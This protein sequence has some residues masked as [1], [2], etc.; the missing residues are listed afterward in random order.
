MTRRL[1]R[2]TLVVTALVLSCAGCGEDTPGPDTAPGDTDGSDTATGDTAGDTSAPRLALG[3]SAGRLAVADGEVSRISLGAFALASFDGDLSAYNWDPWWLPGDSPLLEVFQ[4]P[5]ITWREA[6]LGETDGAFTLD[7]GTSR[8]M[9][10]RRDTP[11]GVTL[12]LDVGEVPYLRFEVRHDP[13]ELLY[14]GGNLHDGPLLNGRRVPMQLEAEPA[15]EPFYNERHVVVPLVVSSAGW[16]LWVETKRA[17]AWDVGRT[18]PGVL[19]VTVGGPVGAVRLHVF[20]VTHPLDVYRAYY[21]ESG[22]PRVPPAW[23]F[24]PWFWRDETP[25]QG[26]ATPDPR[27]NPG[28]MH[29]LATIRDLALP[30]SAYWIDRPYASA[31]NTFDFDPARYH[32]APAML[33]YARS[34]GFAMALWHTPY[35]IEEAATEHADISKIE[36]F[37]DPAGAA[38]NTFGATPVDLTNPA[39]VDYWVDRLDDYISIGIEGFKLDFAEDVVH[40]LPGPRT[41]P[42]GFFSGADERTMWHD[43]AGLYHQTYRKALEAA[44]GGGF[45]LARAGRAG[46]QTRVDV[47]WPGDLD[48]DF[49]A[50]GEDKRVGGIPAALAYAL[51]TSA[52]GYPFFAADTGGYRHG[53]PDN[54]AY[55]R[56]F[57]LTSVMPV[58]QVGGSD[59]QV[60]WEREHFGWDAALLDDYRVHAS[61]HLRLYPYVRALADALTSD[62]PGGGAPLVRPLGLAHPECGTEP[63]DQY[64]LG[65]ALLVAPVV[66]PGVTRRSVVFPT[67]RWVNWWTGEI[68]EGRCAAIDVD[69]PLGRVPLWQREGTLVPLLRP[70]VQTLAPSD[71][72]DS[73]GTTPGAL[74]IKVAGHGAGA[75]SDGAAFVSSAEDGGT[76][77]V[78]T[79]GSRY[80][81]TPVWVF[82]APRP[83]AVTDGAGT[84][85]TEGEE[86]Q[87][88][89]ADGSLYVRAVEARIRW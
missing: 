58:M 25:G 37:P 41:N 23:A 31:L 49:A 35:A 11:D 14:G 55:R 53:P 22:T 88:W 19:E 47:L 30:T 27:H 36:G 64:L 24:G 71:S 76:R 34:Q 50:H 10:D 78:W 13:A 59:N 9:L 42:W 89:W 7:L 40:G 44:D 69:A 82:P 38:L 85:M 26:E 8:V 17:Q 73:A 67:G 65:P 28:V 43:Y 66:A 16:A 2:G 56:W 12:T 33:A 6:P 68:V 72:V 62:A 15:L 80:R 51:S 57:E 20:S 48:A 87:W 54:E 18:T 52:S 83:Q 74:W 5:Q 63:G 1:G 21:R 81:A 32:D 3:L 61:L 60:P 46:G 70:D 4:L 39:V 79:P 86:A 75:S 45:I 77:V 84:P 29:D